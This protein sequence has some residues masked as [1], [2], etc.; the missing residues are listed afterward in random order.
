MKR[1]TESRSNRTK[2]KK[3]RLNPWRLAIFLALLLLFALSASA[4]GM[5]VYSLKDIPAF[6]QARL[7]GSVSTL[8]YD[9]NGDLVTEI[10]IQNRIPVELSA[11]PLEV[12]NAFLAAEDVRF[13]EHIG[14]DFR[15]II[16]A[17]YHNLR[18]GGIH[19]GG[20]TI[21]QQLAKNCF[22]TPERTLKRKIQEAVLALQIERHYHKQEILELYLNQIYFGEGAYGIQAAARTYFNKDVSSLTLAEGALLAAV[23]KAPSLYSPFRNPQAALNRRNLI[24]DNMVRYGFIKP[25]E[26]AAIK[27]EPLRLNPG[28]NRE[29]GYPY[30][31]FVDYVTDRLVDEYGVNRVFR[32]GLRVYTTLD[33]RIQQITEQALQNEKNFPP[34]SRDENGN[35]QPQGSAVI[36]NP[37]N[38][39]ILALVG[40][41]E[42]T[43]RRGL[44]RATDIYRQPG[45]AFKP[46]IAYGPAI[47][48]LGYGPATVVDDIP[49]KFGN[50]PPKNYDGQY[51]GLVTLRTALRRS[52]NIPAVK[53]LKDVG[54]ERATGFAGRLG[55][56]FTPGK[57]GLSLALGGVHKGVTPLQMAQAY[58]AFA[59]QGV[60]TPAIA[61]TRVETADGTVLD[62]FKPK[63]VRVMKPTTA[64]LITDMLR[65]AVEHGTGYRARLGSHPVAGKTGTTDDSKDIWFCGYTPDLVGVVWIGYDEPQEMP[66]A[67]GGLYPAQIWREI[68]S[69]V[70]KEIPPQDFTRPPGI[71]AATVDSKSGLLPGPLTPPEHQV[72]DLFVQGTVPTEVDNTHV[73]VE[74]CAASGLLPTE[75]CPERLTKVLIQLPYTVPSYVKD[76]AERVPTETCNLH[77]EPLPEDNGQDGVTLPGGEGVEPPAETPGQP[78]GESP[79]QPAR[80]KQPEGETSFGDQND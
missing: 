74:V 33:P 12:Q 72:T 46:I 1:E 60:Y 47:E 59:N 14:I 29:K 63:M 20:S 36:L 34:S 77:A 68:M 48:Y 8:L 39:H 71:V 80:Q 45:S 11:I 13:Y 22:L 43:H 37:H 41:R 10:G 27:E 28:N 79:P 54:I 56:E 2:Q 21:T 61:I 16:R 42:Y 57:E 3:R 31:Y 19:E 9:R 55:F 26:A 30:P 4:A 75:Y 66:Q 78:P 76:Y 25:E 17:F 53:V 18:G 5:V 65:S 7:E 70:L 23:P 24:L 35:L 62:E 51:H 73:L 32:A 44:N 52:I 40:G 69:N 38:G 15:A 58:A 64:Y 67:F 6:D 50:Y 49:V